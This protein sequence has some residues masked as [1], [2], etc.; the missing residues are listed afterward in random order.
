MRESRYYCEIARR[1]R[2]VPFVNSYGG[3]YAAELMCSIMILLPAALCF[4]NE[5]GSC[6][7]QVG[8]AA[9]ISKF[10]EK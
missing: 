5:L 3:P 4:G 10:L 1:P 8:N 6:L 9:A 2:I 7:E